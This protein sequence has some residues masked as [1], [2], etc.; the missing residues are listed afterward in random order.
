MCPRREIRL[1]MLHTSSLCSAYRTSSCAYSTGS[2][3]AVVVIT[4]M[5]WREEK[6]QHSDMRLSWTSLL[7]QLLK[8]SEMWDKAQSV[9]WVEVGFVPFYLALCGTQGR[10]GQSRHYNQNNCAHNTV[11]QVDGRYR[12]SH[13]LDKDTYTYIKNT[14]RNTQLIAI[15][16]HIYIISAADQIQMYYTLRRL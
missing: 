6:E 2:S 14:E 1:C 5:A 3:V 12:H 15:K 8:L 11:E 13:G 7:L 10:P 16:F 9:M 4:T